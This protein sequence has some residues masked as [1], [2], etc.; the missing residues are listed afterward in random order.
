MLESSF[1]SVWPENG[2]KLASTNKAIDNVNLVKEMG[3]LFKFL[4]FLN[5][6]CDIFYE[7]LC[8]RIIK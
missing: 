5:W 3:T 4:L 1:G 2:L 8:F 6:S 7:F